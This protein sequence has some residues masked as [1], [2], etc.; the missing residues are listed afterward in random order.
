MK[1]FVAALTVLTAKASPAG[2][3]ILAP[4]SAAAEVKLL[5]VKSNEL[6][7]KVGGVIVGLS[8]NVGA[9]VGLKVGVAVGSGLIRSPAIEGL[10]VGIPDG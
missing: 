9:K 8:V 4:T 2:T 6:A 1:T 10:P 5:F 7:V 3:I